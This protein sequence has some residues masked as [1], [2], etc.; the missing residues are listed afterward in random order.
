MLQVPNIPQYQQPSYNAVKIDIHN[1]AVNAPACPQAPAQM[2]TMPQQQMAANS[3]Y[4]YPQAQLYD[5]PQA[6]QQPYYM[7][8]QQPQYMPQQQAYQPQYQ[9]PVN[10]PQQQV[11]YQPQAYQPQAQQYYPQGGFVCPPCPPA[12]QV[13]VNEAPKAPQATATVPAA[14]PEIVQPEVAVAPQVDL[15]G[16]IAKLANPDYEVQADAME[17]IAQMVKEEPQK[18]TELLDK[19]IV[20][21]LISIINADSSKLA[22]PTE[23]QNA[24][25]QKLMAGQKLSEQEEALAKTITPME[26]AERNKSYAMFTLAILE[27]LYGEEIKKLTGS[28]VPLTELPAAMNIVDQLKDN[29]NPMVRAS[30]IEALSYIQAPEY[31]KDLET[32]F[33]IAKNDQDKGVQEAAAAA[34]DKLAQV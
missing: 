34:L 30:A 7:P 22:G 15:N 27:K 32:L 20:D 26:Q 28:N 21:P 10:M 29:A 1:P 3:P 23:E 18:A 13:N 11:A 25:R 4:N 19:K 8:M 33:S 17:Q 31:K 9:Q 2:G 12:Q 5:Y 16:F 14:Q 6:A 24:A